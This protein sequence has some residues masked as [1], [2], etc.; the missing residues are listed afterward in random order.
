MLRHESVASIEEPEFINLSSNA[1]NPNISE[2]EIKVLYLG[3]NRNGSYID[4]SAA[5]KMSE[6][7]PGTPIVA[8]YVKDK[9]DFGNHGD[10]IHIENGEITFS[11][12]TVPY[13]FVSPD[14]KVWFKNYEDIDEF[15]NH[16]ERTYLMTTGY[17]WTGQYPEITKCISEGMGQS[18]ELD[19]ESMD[20]HWSSDSNTG[21]EF[22]IINDATF[23]KLC[24][25]GSDIEP[26]FEGASVTAPEVSKNFSK[27]D[28]TNS[29]FDMI[30][31]LKFALNDKGGLTMP[32]P[33]DKD[34]AVVDESA[35][36]ESATKELTNEEFAAKEKKEEKLDEDKASEE[37]KKSDS[38]SDEKEVAKDKEA[39]EDE[40]APEDKEE[41]KKKMESNACEDSKKKVKHELEDNE[42]KIAELTAE[43][44]EINGKFDAM[45]AEL[46][47]L[48]AFK[49][50]R[51]S[52]DKDALINKYNMLDDAD[53]AEIIEHKDEYSLDEIESKLA[54]LYVAKNVNFDETDS[55]EEEE[56]VTNFAFNGS[57]EYVAPEDAD[58]LEALR[59]FSY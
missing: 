8:A 53:K 52:A 47:E 38:S 46:E 23:T 51:I 33:Q 54:L 16:V 19:G 5:I 13:G 17:L 34:A 42:A 58:L 48:R 22:F 21:V 26:C 7:L 3:Q 35:A 37:D 56:V 55:N 40:E 15:G 25:L 39:S 12:A 1:L 11:C 20:G 45:N 2:C 32:K 9:D 57:D 6:T 59:A 24:V 18:M 50:E 4:K 28:F 43:I 14:A 29:L 49:A 44:E 41:K 27:N 10:V 30:N 31:E 36:Q